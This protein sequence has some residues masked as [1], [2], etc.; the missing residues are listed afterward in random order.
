MRV[1]STPK[2]LFVLLGDPVHHSLSPALHNEVFRALDL[3]AV[4]VALRA[5]PDLVAALMRAVAVSGG[6]GNVTLP[7]K[8]RAAEALDHATNAVRATGACNVFWWDETKGVCG[9]NGDVAASRVAAEAV[10]GD[11]LAGKRVLLLGAGGA[12]RAVAYACI[13]A[14]AASVDV[15]NRSPGRAWGLIE[16]LGKHDSLRFL[17]ASVMSFSR[18]Y[19]LIVNATSLGL[20]EADPLPLDPREIRATAA[21][22][23]TYRP[24]GTRFVKAAREAAMQ[25]EDGKRMLAEQ[26]ATSFSRW[27]DREAPIDIMYGAV[28]I[29]EDD[30]G[31]G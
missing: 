27:F 13:E 18:S 30:R 29:S 25:A 9:D 23:L 31:A 22:D 8:G 17:D 21:L 3:N 4:Y 7:H 6:G 24:E 2:R 26:A 11:K 15:L 5:W 10:L 20:S 14:R 1:L 16:A 28:G 19:D 12:A